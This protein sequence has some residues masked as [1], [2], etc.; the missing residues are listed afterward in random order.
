MLAISNSVLINTAPGSS[1]F[2]EAAG[3]LRSGTSI[4]NSAFVASP[5]TYLLRLNVQSSNG[6]CVG[7]PFFGS[8]TITHFLVA[9]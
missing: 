2:V 6:S 1:G 9:E 5:G 4:F 7:Q 8:T 3:L